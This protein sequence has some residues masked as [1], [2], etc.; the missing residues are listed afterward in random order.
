MISPLELNDNELLE[1]IENCSLSPSFFTHEVQLRLAWI[2][3]R[4]FGLK[5]AL[6]K[7]NQIKENYYI[8][9]LKSNK[10]NA[11]LTKAYVEILNYFMEKSSTNS[12]DKLLNEFPRLRYNFKNLVKTHYG[13]N[14]LKEH[15]IEEP[16]SN[17]PIL[18][19]F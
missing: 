6:V 1:Q 13:Y 19:T 17:R 4:K 5:L 7:N 14:I 10:F 16:P 3:I 2:L 11:T 9:A 8:T 15:R 18:F 12:F